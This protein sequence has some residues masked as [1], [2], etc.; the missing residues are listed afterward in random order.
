[1]FL[2][3]YEDH[4]CLIIHWYVLSDRTMEY[5]IQRFCRWRS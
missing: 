3:A 2:K 4:V 5:K 1:V